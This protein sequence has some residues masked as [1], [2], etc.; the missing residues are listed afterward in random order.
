MKRKTFLKKLNLNKNTVSH[1]TGSSLKKVRGGKDVCSGDA[2]S[3]L[4]AC[5]VWTCEPELCTYSKC[6]TACGSDPCC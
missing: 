1:L 4:S 3:C 2:S 6:M 5:I